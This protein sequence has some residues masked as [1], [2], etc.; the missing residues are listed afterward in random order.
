M[1][2]SG[3]EGERGGGVGERRGGGG[4]VE[5]VGGEWLWV[6]LM[7]EERAACRVH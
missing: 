3:R 7:V 1:G 4:R 5:E 2:L 6:E